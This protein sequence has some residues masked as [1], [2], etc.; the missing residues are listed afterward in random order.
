MWWIIDCANGFS[1]WKSPLLRKQNITYHIMALRKQVLKALITRG[2]DMDPYHISSHIRAVRKHS[3]WLSTF[4]KIWLWA[5]KRFSPN[6]YLVIEFA[7][8]KYVFFRS[9]YI[10]SFLKRN[11]PQTHYTIYQYAA[12]HYVAAPGYTFFFL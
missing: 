10:L 11:T 8:L 7:S 4:S 1:Q 9:R 3:F 5:V 6:I 2:D 12:L